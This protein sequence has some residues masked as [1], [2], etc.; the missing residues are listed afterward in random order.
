LQFSY[1]ALLFSSLNGV[2][3]RQSTFWQESLGGV[4]NVSLLFCYFMAGDFTFL[5]TKQIQLSCVQLIWYGCVKLKAS[6]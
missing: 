1:L 3:W 5:I 6:L 2:S 4:S